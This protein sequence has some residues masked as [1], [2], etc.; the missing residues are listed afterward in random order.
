MLGAKKEQAPGNLHVCF[1]FKIMRIF[2]TTKNTS[3]FSFCIKIKSVAKKFYKDPRFLVL[4]KTMSLSL[5]VD[6]REFEVR[7]VGS[8]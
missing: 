6:G 1:L 3:F 4:E 2:K 5:D 7:L 8:W